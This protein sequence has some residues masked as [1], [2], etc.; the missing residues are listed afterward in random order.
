MRN[1]NEARFIEQLDVIA[2]SCRVRNQF[3]KLWRKININYAV[4]H[5]ILNDKQREQLKEIIEKLGL[6]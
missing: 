6:I 4:K 5:T 1:P 3:I 2:G